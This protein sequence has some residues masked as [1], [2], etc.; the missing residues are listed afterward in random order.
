MQEAKKL[1]E[2]SCWPVNVTQRGTK[3]EQL[4]VCGYFNWV[5]FQINENAMRNVFKSLSR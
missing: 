3:H 4:N 1:D 5:N 2:N